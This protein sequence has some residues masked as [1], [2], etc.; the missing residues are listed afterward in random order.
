MFKTKNETTKQKSQQQKS[1]Q[2]TL[3]VMGFELN[4]TL[5]I[6]QQLTFNTFG[7]M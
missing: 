5:C 6:I 1:K 2:K 4:L 3:S 7:M